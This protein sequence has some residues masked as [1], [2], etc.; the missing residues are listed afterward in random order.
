MTLRAWPLYGLI[1]LTLQ[2]LPA[3]AHVE[4][5]RG[6]AV[7][8]STSPASV[9]PMP[10]ATTSALPH[11]NMLVAGILS[12][13]YWPQTL[14]T[15]HVCLVD[16]PAR[17]I[18][19]RMLSPLTTLLQ[20]RQVKISAVNTDQLLRSDRILASCNVLYFVS[21]TDRQQQLTIN[22]ARPGT[23]SLSENNPSCS[24]GSAFCLYSQQQSYHFRVNLNALRRAQVQISSKVLSLAKMQE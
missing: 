11:A 20:P 5:A 16:G 10:S 18:D 21:T 14:S 1:A 3:S 24:M 7:A 19:G 4:A 13:V 22:H 2:A 9:L 12:Y 17:A 8:A 6:Y 23:L 15:I